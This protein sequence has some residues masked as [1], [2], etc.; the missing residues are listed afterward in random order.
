MKT[1]CYDTNI[2]LK[3][4]FH[5]HEVD[6]VLIS[7]AVLDELDNQKEREGSISFYAR[8]ARREIEKRQLKDGLIIDLEWKLHDSLPPNW[9]EKNDHI[10][11]S[12]ALRYDAVFVSNDLLP[13]MKAKALGLSTEN[14]IGVDD[15]LA[16]TGMHRL[17]VDDTYF[18]Q[19]VLR[20]IYT[21]GKADGLD[22]IENQYLIVD[23]GKESYYNKIFRQTGGKLVRLKLPHESVITPKNEE[24][25]CA[26][27]LL[28]NKDIPIKIITGTHGTGKTYLTAKIAIDEVLGDPDGI[29]KSL[30]MVRNP[31]GSGEKIGFLKG[32]K[33]DKTGDFFKPIEQHIPSE[34]D[35]AYLEEA[36][37]VKKEIPY[38]MKG[39]SIPDTFI[40]VDEAEDLDKK[41]I[42]LLGGRVAK[43]TCIVFTGD[44]K[45]A[46]DQ[47]MTNN[48]LLYAIEHLK[49]N[50]LV[51][52]VC[53]QEDVR[54]EASKVFADL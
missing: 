46:E 26:L 43:N 53:L 25:A 30:M 16:Y 20:Q 27:D 40:M 8:R 2:L 12:S 17:E 15:T 7:G 29:Y 6:N 47:F 48:G 44:Y 37:L 19:E 11:L 54:S 28:I 49:G 50:P 51:G 14:I 36:R 18:C 1:Y 35:M 23:G 52:I 39:L 3:D 45:Q 9:G 5:I 24:Q 42:K 31:L 32:T 22:L 10:I 41:L 4:P 34:Y 33:E 38:Y 21:E 13:L